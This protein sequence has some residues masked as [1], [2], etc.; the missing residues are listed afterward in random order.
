MPNTQP[1]LRGCVA[2]A[3]PIVAPPCRLP[4]AKSYVTEAILGDGCFQEKM[5]P[6][7]G[8]CELIWGT[9]F[10]EGCGGGSLSQNYPHTSSLV[11]QHL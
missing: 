6:I 4:S 11:P 8:Q 9:V 5:T 2:H 3:A 7:K 10:N 1:S